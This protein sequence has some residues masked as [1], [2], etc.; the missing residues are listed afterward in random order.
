GHIIG[1]TIVVL[2]IRD[3]EFRYLWAGDSRLYRYR[4]GQLEQLTQDHSLY[5]ESINQGLP[6]LDGSLEAGRGN[7]IT[8]AVGADVQLQLD[9]GQGDIEPGDLFILSSD[10]LDKELSHD[11]I[12]RFCQ[13]GSVEDIT[14]QLVQEAE[15]YGGRDNISV[16]AVQTG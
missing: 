3:A 8:R 7:V 15:N 14:R 1:S 4:R 2:L 12:A 11:D 5:N 9:W 6:P 16:I 13:D 10:G